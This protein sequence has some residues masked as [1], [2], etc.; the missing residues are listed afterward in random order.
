MFKIQ[1]QSEQAFYDGLVELMKR[2]AC[3]TAHHH[4]LTITLTGGY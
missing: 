2:G 1:Y 3:Y 4:T